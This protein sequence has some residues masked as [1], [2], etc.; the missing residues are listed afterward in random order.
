MF[1]CLFFSRITGPSGIPGRPDPDLDLSFFSF[2]PFCPFW[3][4]PLFWDLFDFGDFLISPF[5]L[6]LPLNSINIIGPAPLQKCV[7]D[8]CCINF[9]GFCRGFSWRIFLATFEVKKSGEKIHEKNLAA[10]K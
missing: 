1:M 2:V 4:F 5:P 10:Q 8:F 6:S 7:G 3:A 9:G